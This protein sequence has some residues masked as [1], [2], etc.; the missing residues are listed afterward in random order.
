MQKHPLHDN[1]SNFAC[2]LGRTLS[3]VQVHFGKLLLAAIVEQ[4]VILH[5]AATMNHAC[6]WTSSKVN[7][8]GA[9]GYLV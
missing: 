8:H 7:L 1:W 2:K 6:I 9:Q 3:R 5:V 4:A